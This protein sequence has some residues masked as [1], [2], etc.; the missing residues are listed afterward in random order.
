MSE[1]QKRYLEILMYQL[2]AMECNLKV[3]RELNKVGGLKLDL[4]ALEH[5]IVVIQETIEELGD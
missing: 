3:M 4:S 5:E 2:Q 1:E